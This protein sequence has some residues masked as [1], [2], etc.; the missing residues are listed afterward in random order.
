MLAAILPLFARDADGFPPNLGNGEPGLCIDYNS[1]GD[2][3]VFIDESL[4]RDWKQ[5]EEWNPQ[6]HDKPIKILAGQNIQNPD[7]WG[8][9]HDLFPFDEQT[10]FTC[11]YDPN[12][13]MGLPRET[14]V[15][16]TNGL[17]SRNV[18]TLAR[19]RYGLGT[20]QW[21]LGKIGTNIFYNETGR[22]NV[23]YFRTA[24]EKFAVNYFKLPR[25]DDIIWGVKRAL[26]ADEDVGFCTDRSLHWYEGWKDYGWAPN[27]LP[28]FVEF[29]LKDAKHRKIPKHL[30]EH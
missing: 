18:D 26:D 3:V 28:S 16:S 21:F 20:N 14:L 4:K 13:I 25:V 10:V 2:W 19:A 8:N 12:N 22:P 7:S 1:S 23:V 29:S 15:F 11:D 5:G 9:N 24:Q 27:A 6:P 30:P 17:V